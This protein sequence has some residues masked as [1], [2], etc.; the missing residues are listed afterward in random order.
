[1]RVRLFKWAV[2]MFLI[3]VAVGGALFGPALFS[4]LT[5]RNGSFATVK[6]RFE[7]LR[8]FAFWRSPEQKRILK[9]LG[10]HPPG[11]TTADPSGPRIVT[12]KR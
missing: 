4:D 10:G 9:T 8:N 11:S 5:S 6:R 12:P 3:V 2:I 7:R 1:V